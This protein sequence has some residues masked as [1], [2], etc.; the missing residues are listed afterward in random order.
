MV[1]CLLF[2]LIFVLMPLSALLL[3]FFF[4]SRRRHTRWTGDWSSDVCSSDLLVP[5]PCSSAWDSS[6]GFPSC[7]SAG[8]GSRAS[9]SRCSRCWEGPGFCCGGP[10]DSTDERPHATKR[11]LPH[12]GAV[13]RRICLR[14]ADPS[15]LRRS[16]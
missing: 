2:L 11:F 4:S 1:I 6:P 13:I 12:H 3:S 9:R 15:R 8:A 14:K 10:R 7:G 16:G 5:R